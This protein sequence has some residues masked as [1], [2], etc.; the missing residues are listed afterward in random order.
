MK[1]L[2]IVEGESTIDG[3]ASIAWLVCAYNNKEDA[4]S[5]ADLAEKHSID[6]CDGLADCNNPYDIQM[7]KV[8]I[9][10]YNV[11]ECDY[12]N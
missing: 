3:D 4:N 2:Y 11:I 6:Y 8:G 5:H 1:K 9:T 10:V 7:S 12:A